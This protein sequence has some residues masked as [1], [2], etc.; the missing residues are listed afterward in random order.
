MI[1]LKHV[2]TD[3]E[4]NIW[5]LTLGFVWFQFHLKTFHSTESRPS[6]HF[7]VLHPNPLCQMSRTPRS[8]CHGNQTVTREIH[9]SSLMLWSTSV[10][11]LL[12]WVFIT[13]VN[14]RLDDIEVSVSLRLKPVAFTKTFQPSNSFINHLSFLGEIYIGRNLMT[15]DTEFGL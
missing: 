6:S 7:Q 3:G 9:Q 11:K 2:C 4:Q 5:L 14:W 13:F 12:M 15:G 1:V 8:R 10:M